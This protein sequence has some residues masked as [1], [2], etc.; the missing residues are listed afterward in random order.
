M[1]TEK[2]FGQV[3][4]KKNYPVNDWTTAF[5]LLPGKKDVEVICYNKRNYLQFVISGDGKSPAGE[6]GDNRAEG[7]HAKKP[8]KKTENQGVKRRASA[9]VE[10]PIELVARS[11][12][13]F[14]MG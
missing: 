9:V 3:R 7:S 11:K 5:L 14:S 4:V 1:L 2:N 8:A 6:S 13:R 12:R 10:E